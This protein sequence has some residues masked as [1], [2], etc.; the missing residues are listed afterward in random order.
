M[1]CLVHSGIIRTHSAWVKA[2]NTGLGPD[3]QDFKQLMNPCVSDPIRKAQSDYYVITLLDS[4]SSQILENCQIPEGFY[5]LLS[6]TT[7]EFRH[8]PQKGHH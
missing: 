2:R 8:W 1:K 7:N 3:W 6:A 4:N 5:Y